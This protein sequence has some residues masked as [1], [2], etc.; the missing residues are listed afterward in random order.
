[1]AKRYKD[2]IVKEDGFTPAEREHVQTVKQTLIQKIYDPNTGLRF[3]PFSNGNT[4]FAGIAMSDLFLSGGAIASLLQGDEPKDLDIYSH[5]SLDG[6]F[7]T[8]LIADYFD[9]IADITDAYGESE[10][11]GKIIT[12]NAITMKS[13]VQFI[14]MQSG[15][16]AQIKKTFDFV[17]C[18]PHFSF[19]D[20]KLY[21]SKKQYDACVNKKLIVNN[22]TA[23]RNR[24][25][26]KF[27]QRG[28]IL[29]LE[30][31]V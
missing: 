31:G 4:S 20:N 22:H 24:R 7:R 26:E 13:G 17:H 25:I 6:L 12:P 16:P 10:V 23:V 8:K 1:M 14:L 3:A 5:V 27:K 28:Y 19:A 18:T 30:Q 21:I 9:D 11:D 15:T 29:Q 2:S